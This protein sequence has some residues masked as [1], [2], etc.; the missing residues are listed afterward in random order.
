M[1]EEW[2]FAGRG[3]Y[4]VYEVSNLGRVRNRGRILKGATNGRYRVVYMHPLAHRRVDELV[5]AA[6]LP[7][8][9]SPAHEVRHIDGDPGNNRA[10]NLG[11]IL[12]DDQ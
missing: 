10:S 11:W 8:R 9:P 12:A 7:P 3:P 5:A 4:A 2:R 6:F 1:T